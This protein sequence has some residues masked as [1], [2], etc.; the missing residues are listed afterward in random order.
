ML[1]N[2]RYLD[3]ENRE[4]HVDGRKRSAPKVFGADRKGTRYP[5]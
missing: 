5:F 3:T 4:A 2:A 1:H